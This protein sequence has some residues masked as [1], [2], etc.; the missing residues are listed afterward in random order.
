VFLGAFF[1]ATADNRP[2]AKSAF[3]KKNIGLSGKYRGN[4]GALP[5]SWTKKK[6]GRITHRPLLICL[7]N[8]PV[9]PWSALET[10][11]LLGGDIKADCVIS[12]TVA[13][14]FR[15]PKPWAASSGL[16]LRPLLAK[17]LMFSENL[18]RF[19]QL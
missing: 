12:K 6:A 8:P 10:N 14:F 9:H 2:G 19:G 5:I 18:F 17:R 3:Y 15:H 4:N 13:D 16:S 11:L 7:D 1:A